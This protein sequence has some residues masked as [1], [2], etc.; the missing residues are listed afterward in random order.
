MLE[1]YF[2]NEKWLGFDDGTL[3]YIVDYNEEDQSWQWTEVAE[4]CGIYGYTTAAG[5][6]LGAKK[7]YAKRPNLSEDFEPFLTL[8]EMDEILGDMLYEERKDAQVWK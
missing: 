6:K 8:E 4:G 5:A 7:D 1:W 2:E 3:M